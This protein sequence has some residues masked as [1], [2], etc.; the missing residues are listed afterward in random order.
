MV[1]GSLHYILCDY[2]DDIGSNYVDL[3]VFDNELAKAL[4]D[5]SQEKIAVLK[6]EMRDWQ[7]ILDYTRD[8]IYESAYDGRTYSVFEGFGSPQATRGGDRND[9]IATLSI[10][11]SYIFTN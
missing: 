2:I 6:G 3:G 8:Y 9:R 4:S 5:R 11:I 7:L 1:E 10:K